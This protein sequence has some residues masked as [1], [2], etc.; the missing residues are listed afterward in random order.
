MVQWAGDAASL[1]PSPL[2]L[3]VPKSL[4][5]WGRAAKALTAGAVMPQLIYTLTGSVLLNIPLI[6]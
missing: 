6:P 5:T 3:Y 2:E 4:N 1:T